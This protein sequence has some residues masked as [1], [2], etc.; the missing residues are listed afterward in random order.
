[1]KSFTP[2]D[3]TSHNGAERFGYNYNYIHKAFV[4]IVLLSVLE[5]KQNE[6]ALK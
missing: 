3:V 1:M 2:F 4:N 6:S 5:S